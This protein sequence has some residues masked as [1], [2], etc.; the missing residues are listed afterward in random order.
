MLKMSLVSL[1]LAAALSASCGSETPAPQAVPAAVPAS[2]EQGQPLRH[3]VLLRF[4]AGTPA[5][6][7]RRIEQDF[8]AL[9]ERIELI[10]DFE[11]GTN[12]SV[13][14]LAQGYTHCFLVS[15]DNAAARDNYLP[16]PAHRQFAQ[17]LMPH[18]DQVLVVDYQARD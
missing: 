5:D 14:N 18:L 4:K 8:R 7:V 9:R 2:V 10:R 3:V 1:G 11:W 16:H 17:A 6:T 12:V 13:E 15:F